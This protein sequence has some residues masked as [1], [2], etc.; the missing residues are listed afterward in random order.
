MHADF[1]C[2]FFFCLFVFCFFVVVFFFKLLSYPC[3][4]EPKCCRHG[5]SRQQDWPLTSRVNLSLYSEGF[6]PV[7][8]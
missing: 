1:A 4:Q 6:W 7:G 2:F 3:H 5:Q 8:S